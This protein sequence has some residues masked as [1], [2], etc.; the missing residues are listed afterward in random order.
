MVS[1]SGRPR[2]YFVKS[3]SS[4][5]GKLIT[6]MCSYTILC[7]CRFGFERP[8]M[9]LDPGQSLTNAASRPSSGS[10]SLW[11]QSCQSQKERHSNWVLVYNA[12]FCDAWEWRNAVHRVAPVLTWDRPILDWGISRHCRIQLACPGVVTNDR[13]R[14]R[15]FLLSSLELFHI[16]FKDHSPSICVYT[17]VV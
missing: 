1:P 10:V 8:L 4:L 13:P 2:E 3:P 17:R 11:V 6:S 7:V 12:R 9:S 14:R 16:F 5:S 15:L